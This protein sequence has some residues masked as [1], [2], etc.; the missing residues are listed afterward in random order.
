LN[1]QFV[2][3]PGMYGAIQALLC[4]ETF[5]DKK[6][7]ISDLTDAHFCFV[8]DSIINPDSASVAAYDNK[9]YTG[10]NWYPGAL[11]PLYTAL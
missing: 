5:T 3:Q 4:L 10:Y 2:Y 11:A 7:S 6:V 8:D 1:N 9:A